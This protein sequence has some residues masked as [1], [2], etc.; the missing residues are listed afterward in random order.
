LIV[1]LHQEINK[2]PPQ[3]QKVF[4]MNRFEQ[5][6]YKEIAI[7]LNLSERTVENHIATALKLLRL[8]L[9]TDNPDKKVKKRNDLLLSLFLY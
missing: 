2:L 3:C 6:K 7:R 1:L 9:L 4:K 8:A 5:L